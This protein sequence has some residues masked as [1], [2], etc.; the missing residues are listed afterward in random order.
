MQLLKYIASLTI[1]T[2]T[3]DDFKPIKEAVDLLFSVEIYSQPLLD[4]C[5]KSVNSVK[6]QSIFFLLFKQK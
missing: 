6:N 2:E 3:F 5:I 1:L 4:S